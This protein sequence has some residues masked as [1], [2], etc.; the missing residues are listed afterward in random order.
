[1]VKKKSGFERSQEGWLPRSACEMRD[2]NTESA[3]A[4]AFRV[5]IL[6]YFQKESVVCF[7][8]HS[9][10]RKKEMDGQPVVAPLI[11]AP[12]VVPLGL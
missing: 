10:I 7:E 1:M 8:G 12:L 5:K 3:M 9:Q 6:D 11:V 4:S 2:L